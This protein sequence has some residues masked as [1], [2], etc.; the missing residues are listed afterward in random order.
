MKAA[1][2]SQ[3]GGPEVIEI[4]E[5]GKPLPQAGQV[6]VE[7]QAA[8]IN[9]FD[10][11]MR[12]GYVKGAIKSLPI[13]LGGD[14]SGVVESG[15][16]QFQPGDEVY[17]SALI[18]SGGSGAL[19]ELATTKPENIAKKPAKLNH[20]EAASLVLVGVSAFQALDQLKLKPASKLLI[21]GGAGGIGSAAI[22]YAKHLGTYVA[23]TVREADVAFVKSLGADQVIDY[24]KAK[25]SEKLHNFDAVFDT[26]GDEVYKDSFKVLKKG[27]PIIS[28]TMPPDEELAT[29]YQV[30]AL[31]QGTKVNIE[32]LNRLT[33]L[34]EGNVITPHV[35]KEFPLAQTAEAFKHLETGHPK[36]KV[37]IKIG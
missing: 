21:Q 37:V 32:S 8:A 28:M 1:Q 17:G 4:N 31:Y 7:V 18:L 5:V 20:S 14:F 11:K 3:Y 19:A 27:G 34:I 15:A 29:K 6:L 23:T 10:W 9:P 36:G 35:D 25:A 12:E 13:T 24:Q 16:D 2:I 26:V 22:Q 33:K 30:K